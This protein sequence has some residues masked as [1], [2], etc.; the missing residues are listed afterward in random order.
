MVPHNP[1]SS[2][3]IKTL[4]DYAQHYEAL[5]A[6][7]TEP[8][9]DGDGHLYTDVVVLWPSDLLMT[10]RERRANLRERQMRDE[11]RDHDKSPIARSKRAKKHKEGHTPNGGGAGG[12]GGGSPGHQWP[13][14]GG[15]AAKKARY[16]E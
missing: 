12:Q 10:E 15:S 9:V 6:P 4:Y 3:S 11:R 14:G 13:Q 5:R 1:N 2:Y 16:R 7:I 8:G